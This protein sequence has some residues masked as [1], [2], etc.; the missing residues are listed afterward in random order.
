MFLQCLRLPHIDLPTKMK[1]L[2]M[3][4]LLISAATG[5]RCQKKS[6]FTTDLA[7]AICFG[8]IDISFAHQI[9]DKWSITGQ[10]ALNIKRL[11]NGKDMETL[12]HQNALSGSDNQDGKRAFRNNLTEVSISAG[13]WPHGAF[14]GVSFNLG[15]IIKDRSGPDIFCSIG[16]TV[17]IWKGLA[18]DLGY[19]LLIMETIKNKAIQYNGI[20]IGISYVF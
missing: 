15:G 2:I 16:Y 4:L 18:A 9:A 17:P 7:S 6:G 19:R 1:R 13:F 5:A 12:Q 10:T 20:R 14:Q 8:T 11:A 3:I